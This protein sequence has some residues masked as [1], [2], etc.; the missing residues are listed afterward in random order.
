MKARHETVV[1]NKHG[2]PV[3]KLVPVTS[4]VDDIF[5][6]FL[7]KGSISGDALAPALSPEEWG[8]VR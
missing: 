1:T 5:G 7:G 6:F 4:D 2:E 3:A 8:S